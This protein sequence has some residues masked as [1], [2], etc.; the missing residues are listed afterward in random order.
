MA[1][2]ETSNAQSVALAA[3]SLAC[4]QRRAV[5][6][7]R[8]RNRRVRIWIVKQLIVT[9]DDFGASL[10]I[11]E[12]VERA[13]R[14]GVLTSASLM[15]GE[16]FAEDAVRR[17]RTMPEL[18]VG[19]HVA[20]TNGRPVLPASRVPDLVDRSGRFDHHLVRAGLRY[21]FLPRVR[22]QLEDEIRA[23]FDAYAQT[24]LAL[25]HVDAHN[26]LHVH[27]ALFSLLVRIGREFGMRAMR[28]PI[29]P[30]TLSAAGIANA[31]VI[32]PWAAT[33]RARL[34]RLGFKANDAVFG[35]NDTGRLDEER[36]LQILARLP[37]GLSELYFHVT[38]HRSEARRARGDTDASSYARIEE[39]DAL[40]SPR[41][42]KAIEERGVELTTYAKSDG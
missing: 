33:M 36:V 25:D 7:N 4:A 6:E 39:L 20:L 3:G 37:N 31:I 30:F 15:V 18:A 26:H 12:A 5:R 19:L 24:G 2:S 34:R 16:A 14:E 8:R 22:W 28:V 1:P 35:L 32:G 17:A 29:E 42:R 9:A 38:S 40:L 41:V 21:F 10:Q 23:Q 13:H 11:N 27:P